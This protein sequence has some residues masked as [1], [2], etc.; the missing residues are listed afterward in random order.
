MAVM[1][2]RY[3]VAVIGL[4]AMGSATLSE[5]ARRGRRAIGFDRFTPPHAFGSSHGE[6][7][8]IREAY[9]EHPLYVPLVQ[10]AYALW[11]ALERRSGRLLLAPTGGLMIGAADTSLVAGALRSARTHGLAHD[12]LTAEEIRRAYPAMR[13]PDA[14][15]GVREPR[16]GVLFPERGIDT[17]L[18]LAIEDGADVRVDAR[19]T[20]W[21]ADARGVTIDAVMGDAASGGGERMRCEA[22]QIVLSCGPW[23]KSMAPDLGLPLSVERTVLHW[24]EPRARAD[25]FQSGRFPIFLLEDDR[26]HVLYGV[27]EM[28]GVGVGAD[29]GA[30]V[31]VALHHHGEQTTGD[32]VRRE[33]SAEEVREIA[34]LAPAYFPDLAGGWRRAAVCMYTNMPDGHF[35]IDRHPRHDAVWIVS[36]CSGHGFKFAPVIGEL[37]ADLVSGRPAPFDLAPFRLDRGTASR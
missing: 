29:V 26:G 18:R 32:A 23:M 37:V 2:D 5:L 9:F 36:P 6:T 10:R 35:L 19:V 31:K 16:A 34:E 15:I 11:A 7:R 21:T 28:P 17:F 3:D 30:G 14:M 12:V 8:I 25:R 13:I 22:D 4:G 33:V 24:F 27:P 1:T 20:S